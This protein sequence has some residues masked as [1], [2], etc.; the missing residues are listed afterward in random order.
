[1]FK[2]GDVVRFHS[3]VA[4][5][6]KYHLCISLSGGFLFLNTYRN[7]SFSGD[8]VVPCSEIACL[9]P[10]ESGKSVVSCSL[11]I[12]M[13]AEALNHGKATKLGVV[14]NSLLLDIIKYI[15]VSPVLSG[16]DKD[17]VLDGLGDWL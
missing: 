12:R 8:L 15:E 16:E 5:K 6:T 11:I 2:P 10:T 4:G 13:D 14:N 7:R 3:Y 1:M 9:P 17:F